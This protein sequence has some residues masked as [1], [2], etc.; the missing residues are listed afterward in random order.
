MSYHLVTCRLSI[1][2]TIRYPLAK[3]N[4]RRNW[5]PFLSTIRV[6]KGYDILPQGNEEYILLCLTVLILLGPATSEFLRTPLLFTVITSLDFTLVFSSY[7]FP[8]FF[9]FSLALCS[10]C[11][12]L[13]LLF[14]IYLYLPKNP[15]HC[16][17]LLFTLHVPR[18][19]NFLLLPFFSS[20]LGLSNSY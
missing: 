3:V 19:F 4:Y 5:H 11:V 7:S 13:L 12:L 8:T 17:H 15:P 20:F 1:A 6:I 10:S 9:N 2:E 16:L 18:L 14:V